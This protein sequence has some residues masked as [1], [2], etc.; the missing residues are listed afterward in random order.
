MPLAQVTLVA[1]SKGFDGKTLVENEHLIKRYLLGEASDDECSF[2]ERR[3]LTDRDYF[4]RLVR[5]EEELTDQYVQDQLDESER[6][7]FENHFMLAPEH[8][9]QV[10]FAVTL[11]RY[12]APA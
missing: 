8:R 1:D 5:I 11:N 7:R 12:L 4:S 10:N 9:E 3:L 6:Q 2:V